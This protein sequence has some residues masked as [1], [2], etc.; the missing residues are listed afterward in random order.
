MDTWF[1]QARERFAIWILLAGVVFVALLVNRFQRARR[2]K[3]RRIVILFALAI[4]TEIASSITA[5]THSVAWHERMEFASSLFEAFV[6]INLVV[7]TVFDVIIPAVAVAIPV[8]VSDLIVGAAY[9]VAT[10]GAMHAAGVNPSS[11]LGASAVVS[12]VVALSL[13]STLGNVIGGVALQLD[14]SVHV[15]DWIQLENG[16]QGKVK[17]IRW[18]HTVLETR[19]WGTLIVPNSTLLQSQI[20]VL[21]KREGQPKQH[22]YW[23]YFNVD[24]RFL[25]SRVIDVVN[26]CLQDGDIPNVAREPKPHCIC[27]DFAKDN[28]DSMVHYA[29]RYWLTDL[30]VDDPTNSLVRTRIFMALKRASIPFAR[31]AQT[32]FVLPEE[33]NDSRRARH[34]GRRISALRNMALFASLTDDERNRLADHLIFAPFTR[35]ELVTAKGKVAHWLYILISGSVDIQITEGKQT[36]VLTTIE[37]P[38]FFGEMGML[39]GAPRAADVLAKTDVECYRL[40]KAG[41]KEV[42]LARPEL[43][44]EM[45]KTMAERH[46]ELIAAQGGMADEQKAKFAKEEEARILARVEEFFG[47]SG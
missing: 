44:K 38:G 37:A 30:A 31:P 4:I 46:A 16:R 47:L 8:I 42:M 27:Y 36:K 24:Y 1:D 9:V 43:A 35:G 28:R 7:I 33:D 26:A 18:R 20:L 22:R 45:S 41:F 19:D 32:N 10:F 14:G 6:V 17:E 2:R 15:N 5:A 34:V 29:V 23:I 3:L 12:A 11:V 13:Q 39:T 40:D 21:A 25:P